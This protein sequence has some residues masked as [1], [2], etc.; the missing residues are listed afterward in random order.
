VADLQQHLLNGDVDTVARSVRF[1]LRVNATGN[2]RWIRN[3]V[4]LREA[5]GATFTADVTRMVLKCPLG[6]LYCDARGVMVG[7][8]ELW[9]A[10]ADAAAGRFEPRIIAVNLD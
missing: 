5:F 9:L 10:P 6:G 1:P 8:G 3:E 2:T 4:E 7:S